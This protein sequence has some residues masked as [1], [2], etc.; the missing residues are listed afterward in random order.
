MLNRVKHQNEGDEEF[1]VDT[2]EAG[3]VTGLLHMMTCGD[4]DPAF[5][6]IKAEAEAKARKSEKEIAHG[7]GLMFEG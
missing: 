5:T 6:T 7:H 4:P 2:K 1:L 3:S